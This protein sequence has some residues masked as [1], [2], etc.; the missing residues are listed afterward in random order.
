MEL[1]LLSSNRKK[2]LI[3]LIKIFIICNSSAQQFAG[4]HGDYLGQRTPIDTPLVFAPELI[5]TK[6]LEH[7]SAVCSENGNT[8]VWCSIQDDI[9]KLFQM[10]R[11]NNQWTKPYLLD[12]FNDSCKIWSDGPMFFPGTNTLF[13]NTPRRKSDSSGSWLDSENRIW[14]A[15]LINGDWSKPLPYN[16][17]INSDIRQISF[18]RDST[19]Y[20]VDK[21]QGAWNEIGIFYSRYKHGKYEIPQTMPLEISESFQNWTPFVSPDESYLIYSKCVNHGDFG[22]L[23]ITYY[24]ENIKKWSI[25]QNLGKPINTR[26]QER[27]PSVSPDG[28]FLFF[29]RWT[30]DNNQDVYWVKADIISILKLKAKWE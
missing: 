24:D 19:I 25:P 3:I 10:R 13:F 7:S 15:E 11:I 26:A 6:Y 5:S 21:L 18:T 9:K 4:L 20:Y 8:V 2:G 17:L 22:D 14:S 16:N 23:Y 29:T 27:F 1:N 28:K 12:L 30:K